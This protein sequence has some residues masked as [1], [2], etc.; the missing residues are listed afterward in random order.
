MTTKHRRVYQAGPELACG[1]VRGV[2]WCPEAEL[3]WE[4]VAN[5]HR[6]Y[7]RHRDKP[8]RGRVGTPTLQP[9]IAALAAF[10]AHFTQPAEPAEQPSLGAL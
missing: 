4:R 7:A 3:L 5:A 2:N 1:C 6:D 10:E 9:Y 8:P